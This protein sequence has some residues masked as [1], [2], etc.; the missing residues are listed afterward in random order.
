MNGTNKKLWKS[1]IGIKIG[2]NGTNKKLWESF[3]VKKRLNFKN[4]DA[5]L[6]FVL[7]EPSAFYAEEI[8]AAVEGVGT[9]ET[10]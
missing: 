7:D 8:F 5:C 2:M 3:I 6:V 4:I 1:F 9:K 10:R